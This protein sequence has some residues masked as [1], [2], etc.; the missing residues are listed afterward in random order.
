MPESPVRRVGELT[1]KVGLE[2]AGEI[3][4]DD[5]QWSVIQVLVQNGSSMYCMAACIKGTRSRFAHA[6][7]IHYVMH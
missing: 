1:V 3:S 7:E 4:A 6:H 2:C 5:R